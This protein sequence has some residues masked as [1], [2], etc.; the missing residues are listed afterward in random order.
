MER[1]ELHQNIVGCCQYRSSLELFHRLHGMVRC[2]TPT[3]HGHLS[4]KRLELHVLHAH[5]AIDTVALTGGY[6]AVR[7]VIV[8]HARKRTPLDKFQRRF[9]PKPGGHT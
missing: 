2:F 4:M 6:P 5:E 8:N 7:R 9:S 3:Q 1:F